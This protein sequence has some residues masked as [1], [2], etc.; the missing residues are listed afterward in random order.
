MVYEN[1][2]PF[3]VTITL[4]FLLM[5]KQKIGLPTLKSFYFLIKIITRCIVFGEALSILILY[6]NIM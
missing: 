2:G 4:A 1:F 5:S 6:I 3:E